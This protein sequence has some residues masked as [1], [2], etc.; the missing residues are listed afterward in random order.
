MV[1][2][3]GDW[4][5]HPFGWGAGGG[6]F[7]VPSARPRRMRGRGGRRVD[8]GDP[9]RTPRI[10]VIEDEPGI[11]DFLALGLAHEGFAAEVA[12]DGATGL[13]LAV[14]HAPDLVVLDV[15]LPGI[16]GF[17]VCERLRAVS[18]VP[19]I[20]LTARQDL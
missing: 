19:V 17:T 2:W 9:G 20:M 12:R 10:L 8:E 7:R 4:G 18:S 3:D 1:A 13:R 5:K 14:E 11:V 16:D 6:F 15:M